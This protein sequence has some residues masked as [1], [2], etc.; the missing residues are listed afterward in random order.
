MS[1]KGYSIAAK[2]SGYEGFLTQAELEH[3]QCIVNNP[4]TTVID[5]F[6]YPLV[7]SKIEGNYISVSVENFGQ[8]RR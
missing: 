8:G 7:F 4:V 5:D 3:S 6:S 2:I 1:Q